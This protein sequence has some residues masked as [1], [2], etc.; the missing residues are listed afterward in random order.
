[1]LRQHYS[2][3]VWLATLAVLAV[4]LPGS[5]RAQAQT[6]VGATEPIILAAADGRAGDTFGAC[7]SVEHNWLAAGSLRHDPGAPL[8]QGA[9]YLYAY[10]DGGW[11]AHS[12]LTAGDGASGDYFGQSCDLG[13]PLLAVGAP[14]QDAGGKADSGAVYL[15]RLTNGEWSQGA[16]LS[17]PDG[18]PGDE[19]GSAV[20]LAEPYLF[21]GAPKADVGGTEEQ[22]AIYVFER[23]GAAWV[24]HS[25]LTFPGGSR[26]AHF[27]SRL[28]VSGGRLIAGAPGHSAG[29]RRNRGAA[30]VFVLHDGAWLHESTLLAPDGAQDDEFG[31]AVALDGTVAV[32]GAD[33]DDR[34]SPDQGSVYAFS[35]DGGAW[36]YTTH[37]TGEGTVE[38]SYFGETV[39]L[40]GDTLLVGA[41]GHSTA[42]YSRQG[43]AFRYAREGNQWRLEAMT[44]APDG[45]GGDWFGRGIAF[46]GYTTTIAAP[47]A[48]VGTYSDAGK[49][50]V[51]GKPM[52]IAAGFRSW[53][54]QV[55]R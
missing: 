35:L 4:L 55:A 53:L 9:L 19:L 10:T 27:G 40:R 25:K 34:G 31:S 28:A 6:A 48:N 7:V 14:R 22:G 16:K 47:R 29:G 32:V 1:M 49:I 12:K 44:I 15:F 11:A 21:A 46:D 50:Y 8:G 3:V 45:T 20:F 36:V 52:E 23:D 39:V 51:Y 2:R 43:M 24:F 41:W 13:G 37:F 42:G 5:G 26:G 18:Q 30:A 17:A 33:H 38:D 54:P